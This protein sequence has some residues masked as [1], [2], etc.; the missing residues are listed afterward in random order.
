M[1]TETATKQT[2]P[3]KGRPRRSATPPHERE[4]GVMEHLGELRV[5]LFRALILVAIATAFVWFYFDPLYNF[6][7]IPIRAYMKEG[8]RIVVTNWLEPFFLQLKLSFYG[9]LVVSAPFW[10]LELWGFVAPALTP[11]E[12]KPIRLLAPMT[13]V[14]FLMGVAVAHITLPMA[15]QWALGYMPENVQLMQRAGDYVELLAKMYLAFGVCFE[16]PI[17]LMFLAKVGLIDAQL[18]RRYWRHAIIIIMTVAA[19][20]TPSNDPITMTI[21]AVPMGFLYLLSIYLVEWMNKPP[22]ESAAGGDA[23]AD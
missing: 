17:L 6:F 13:V 19:V 7:T 10:I 23:V 3:T 11:E 14:L 15:F 2:R 20:I 12:R 18:M 8:D 22:K 21:C 4:M 5:R 1:A 16:L 9:G